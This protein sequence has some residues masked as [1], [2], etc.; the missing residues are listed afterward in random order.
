M[1]RPQAPGSWATLI[2]WRRWI[3][4]FHT[5]RPE[6]MTWVQYQA[7]PLE[8]RRAFDHQRRLWL[9]RGFRINTPE[10][11]LAQDRLHRRLFANELKDTGEGGILI[12]SDVPYCGK[13]TILRAL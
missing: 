10:L 3:D 1:R 4:E 6:C 8:D 11:L 13:T 5:P 2:G 7:M 12:T 9:T